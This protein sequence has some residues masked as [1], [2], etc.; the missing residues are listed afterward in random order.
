MFP[1]VP[2]E[3]NVQSGTRGNI[4]GLSYK[5]AKTFP[6]VPDPEKVPVETFYRVPVETFWFAQK[7]FDGYPIGLA[8]P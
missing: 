7:G 8:A 6:R 3:K 5:S 1:R 2:D 4:L